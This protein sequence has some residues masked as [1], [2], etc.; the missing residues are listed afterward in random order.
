MSVLSK[1]YLMR[2]VK[3]YLGI[4]FGTGL[5]SCGV[6][7]FMLPYGLTS[8]GVTGICSIIY[9]ATGIE[10]ENTYLLFNIMLLFVAAKLLGFRFCIKTA[11]GVGSV[12]VWLWIW[13]RIIEDP[14]T[15][16]LPQLVGTEMFMA[17]VLGAILEGIGLSFCFDNN[18]STGGSDIVAACVNKY[19]DVSLGQVIMLL[20]IIIISSS[21]FVFH[22]WNR[23]IF[24]FVLLIVASMTLDYMMR[25]A[26]QA[27]EFK[28]FSRNYSKIANAII[29]ADFGVTVLEGKGWYTQT[30]RK[31]LICICSKRYKE[32]IM[33][34]I[35]TVDPNAF[36]SVSYVREVYG[37]GF[38]TMKTKIKGQKP[39]IV[40]ATNNKNKLAEVRAILGERFEIRSLEEVGCNVEL[41]ETHN[42][43]EENAL[44]KAR[45]LNL[46]YGFN[47]FAD[48]TGLEVE[49][50]E[51]MPG[52]YSAR[53]ANI[54][55]AEYDDPEMDKSKD[56]DSEANMR[57]LLF[58]LKGKENRKAQ[59]RTVIALIYNNK[60]YIFDGIVKGEIAT[61]K[62]GT[63]G[64]GYDPVFY[65]YKE[66]PAVEE[67]K[68]LLD[69]TFAEMDGKDKN[70]ISHR[71]RAIEQLVKWLEK[72]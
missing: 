18:G 64:F 10:V 70:A 8:G 25:R 16:Q 50:L 40:F 67:P 7:L 72:N 47:C 56:H 1:D 51:G 29:E 68:T 65:P 44:E 38:G 54:E 14:A 66:D 33:R 36:V 69:T 45:Y 26:H 35:K 71:G 9:Y 63:E 58:K 22:D 48:D 11:W 31:V 57:K 12:T 3:D 41:P 43:L 2:E 61:E 53:Y 19:K 15:H 46:Y 20:D 32:I 13:Q 39:I 5:Y 55:D 28:I 49:S 21:Y 17:C 42:T 6:A 37:E 24:G 23:V 4:I 34:A 62:H 30:E 27:V 52:V 59:F 60:E